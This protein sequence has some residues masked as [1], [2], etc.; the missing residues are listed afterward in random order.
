[1]G[2]EHSQQPCS[3][4]GVLQAA[5][6]TAHQGDLGLVRVQWLDLQPVF[7]GGQHDGGVAP[8][9]VL[10]E[11]GA[12]V[13]T[14][15]CGIFQTLG[16]GRGGARHVRGEPLSPIHPPL[17][18]SLAPPH[19]EEGVPFCAAELKQGVEWDADDGGQ[20]HEE[21]DGH[22]PAWILVVVI[23]DWPVLDHREDENELQS[24]GWEWA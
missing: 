4:P 24:G 5:S 22:C 8:S 21:A 15:L 16:E 13:S 3:Y 12:P 19:L 2:L 20:R 17:P 9:P 11:G 18:S 6:V 7:R 14:W 1:M 23:G 10:Q